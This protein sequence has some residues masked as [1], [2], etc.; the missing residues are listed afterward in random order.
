MLTYRSQ[1]Y[2]W[3]NTL[4]IPDKKQD[5]LRDNLSKYLTVLEEK[6]YPYDKF[7]LQFSGYYTDNSP[8]SVKP[9]DII[10][11]WN[12]KYEWPKLRSSLARDFMIYLDEQHADD[13]PEQKVAWPDWWTDGVASAANE[14]KEVRKAHVN[15][16]AVTSIL[17]MG[18]IAGVK[19][20][21]NFQ[22]EIEKVYDDLLFYDEHT[23]GAAESISDP[24]IQNTINQWGMKSSYAW[25]AAREVNILEEKALAFFEVALNESSLP[26]IAV[27]NTLNWQRSGMIELFIQ[28]EIFTARKRFYN[29]GCYWKRSAIPNV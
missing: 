23:H 15:I 19:L 7:S 22:N 6:N 28:H 18:K 9:C 3:G 24:L 10:K 1:H 13:L 29:N 21:E 8:P 25:D 4:G 17:S 27:F 11:E 20:P 14:T 26:T 2:H 5:E 12:E 16:S